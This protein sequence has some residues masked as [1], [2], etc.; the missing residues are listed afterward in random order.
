MLENLIKI[1]DE[2]LNTLKRICGDVLTIVD[3]RSSNMSGVVM[4]ACAMGGALLI[5]NVAEPM[6]LLLM[7]LIEPRI[8]TKRENR[9]VCLRF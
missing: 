4:S 1:L 3:Q 8:I 5:E 9:M 2:L 6:P 7:Q